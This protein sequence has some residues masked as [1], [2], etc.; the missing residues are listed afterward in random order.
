MKDG[1]KLAE[2][3]I[4]SGKALTQLEKFVALSTE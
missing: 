2:E 4:D 3:I 1:I